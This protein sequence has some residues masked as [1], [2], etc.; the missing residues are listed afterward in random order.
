ML[1]RSSCV[2]VVV[3][4][5]AAAAEAVAPVLVATVNCA[6]AHL[7]YCRGQGF[8]LHGFL[9]SLSSCACCCVCT[10]A[11]FVVAWPVVSAIVSPLLWMWCL[12][13]MCGI[14]AHLDCVTRI[15]APLPCKVSL[16]EL[17]ISSIV[18]AWLCLSSIVSSQLCDH[19][20]CI[21]FSLWLYC[22][23]AQGLDPGIVHEHYCMCIVHMVHQHCI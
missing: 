10:V 18:T 2:F 21:V 9:C 20:R 22:P 17:S 13:C 7:T 4:A 23:K 3:V 16:F 12:C 8:V 6:K 11:L 14:G 15:T 19:S 1:V 5:A